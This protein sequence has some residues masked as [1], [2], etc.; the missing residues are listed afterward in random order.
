MIS[1]IGLFVLLLVCTG[2]FFLSG[3]WILCQLLDFK[4]PT[5]LQLFLGT[6]TGMVAFS[7]ITALFYT[8][9]KSIFSVL[10]VLSAA[11]IFLVSKTRKEKLES[12]LV[13]A[14][15]VKSSKTNWVSLLLVLLIVFSW[16]ARLVLGQNFELNLPANPETIIYA[17]FSKII[18]NTGVEST[19]RIGLLPQNVYSTCTPYHYLDLWCT[20]GF[21]KLVGITELQ[22]IHF[23]TLPLLTF[24]NILGVC[25]LLE[26]KT[27]VQFYHPLLAFLLLFIG[28]C[29]FFPYGEEF[30]RYSVDFVEPIVA[31][32]GEKLSFAFTGFLVFFLLFLK[33]KKTEALL[34]LLLIPLLYPSLLFSINFAVPLFCFLSWRL[35][36]ITSRTLLLLL[37]FQLLV[38]LAYSHFYRQ[39]GNESSALISFSDYKGLNIASLKMIVAEIFYRSHWKPFRSLLL[40]F[41]FIFLLVISYF[42]NPKLEMQ[43]SLLLLGLLMYLGA[44]LSWALFYK[45]PEAHQLYSNSFT[46][47]HVLMVLL[48]IDW[49]LI[50]SYSK[51]RN[52][53]AIALFTLLLW[54]SYFSFQEYKNIGKKYNYSPKFLSQIK[55]QNFAITKTFPVAYLKAANEYISPMEY[56]T[57]GLTGAYLQLEKSFYGLVAIG[58]EEL[59]DDSILSSDSKKQFYRQDFYQFVEKEKQLNNYQSADLSQLRFIQKHDIQYVAVSPKSTIPRLLLQNTES[60]ITDSGSGEKF[61]ILKKSITFK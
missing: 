50:T 13:A 46:F 33:H 10:F 21:S 48:F 11:V 16:F 4:G 35:K 26:R 47:L 23:F 28:A 2:L 53:L 45:L 52:A 34:I 43:K 51:E 60:I 22:A 25:A 15:Q 29:V 1:I 9:L 58:F 24:I 41:P 7:G 5:Y 39:F 14:T 42:K 27:K 3:R 40:Y 19:F 30:T 57:G 56:S 44:L 20:A 54:S 31:L 36:K 59:L 17:Q 32:Y 38:L 61:L 6:L 8:H 18:A 55:Q 12:K 37:L 49:I